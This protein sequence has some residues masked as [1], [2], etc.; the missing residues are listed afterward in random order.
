MSTR[1]SDPPAAAPTA[2]PTPIDS[3]NDWTT[4]GRLSTVCAARASFALPVRRSW[5]ACRSVTGALARSAATRARAV[6]A[7]A[8][9]AATRATA[10][11]RSVIRVVTDIDR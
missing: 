6:A 3:S 1:A 8:S 10:T 7:L 5:T 4:I 2:T 9:T 11:H